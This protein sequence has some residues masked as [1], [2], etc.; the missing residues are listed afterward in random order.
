MAA[1]STGSSSDQ[2]SKSSFLTG[3]FRTSSRETPTTS[4]AEVS[5]NE[6]PSKK[7][8]SI[9]TRRRPS[10]KRNDK[11]RRE[12]K[13]ELLAFSTSKDRIKGAVAVHPPLLPV[14]PDTDAARRMT[15]LCTLAMATTMSWA[16]LSVRCPYPVASQTHASVRLW[17]YIRGPTGYLQASEP[18]S[19]PQDD[20]VRRQRQH[21][22]DAARGAAHV[23]LKASERECYST[24][25]R[26]AYVR[27]DPTCTRR[28]GQW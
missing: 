13:R 6:R 19:C 25:P 1:A 5:D 22:H 11:E 14:L 24:L 26:N 10:T 27:V 23:A 21:H 9:W 20:G 16:K 7:E 17:C 12:S 28:L 15:G 2:S 8:G 3:L 4:S 18:V